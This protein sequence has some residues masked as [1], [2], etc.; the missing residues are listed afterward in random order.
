MIGLYDEVVSA[1]PAINLEE[2]HNDFLNVFVESD[3]N[4]VVALESALLEKHSNFQITDLDILDAL[5]KKNQAAAQDPSKH[6]HHLQ[7]V[8]ATKL[9]QQEFDLWKA[10]VLHEVEQ[11]LRWR[12]CTQDAKAIQYYKELHHRVRRSQEAELAAASL[13]DMKHINCRVQLLCDV[14]KD[15]VVLA[16]AI[17]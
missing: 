14:N 11:F 8:D 1:C 17:M 13:F 3:P 6:V 5:I 12:A 16:V 4:L 9:E 2:L 7:K 10:H 15:D